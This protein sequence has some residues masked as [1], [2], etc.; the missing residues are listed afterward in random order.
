[1]LQQ[2]QQVRSIL[3]FNAPASNH[4]TKQQHQQQNGESGNNGNSKPQRNN[5]GRK[6][7]NSNSSSWKTSTSS[8]EKTSN[9]RNLWDLNTITHQQQ[10]QVKGITSPTSSQSSKDSLSS[11]WFTPPQSHSPA[12]SAAGEYV[13]S[14]PVKAEAAKKSPSPPAQVGRMIRAQDLSGGTGGTN[15]WSSPPPQLPSSKLVGA[16]ERFQQSGIGGWSLATGGATAAVTG[17]D[18][19]RELRNNLFVDGAK[20]SN[21]SLQLFSD[22]FLSYLNMIN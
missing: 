14:T 1:M 17:C 4:E 12:S 11:I 3:K 19:E 16:G 15:I 20:A 7:N 10:Q 21:A 5:N 13:T 6:N 22:N 9:T 8:S 18:G 2:Q